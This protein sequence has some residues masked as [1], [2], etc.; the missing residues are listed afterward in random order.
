M[1]P[2]P[3]SLHDECTGRRLHPPRHP[4]RGRS[5]LWYALGKPSPADERAR[6]R[7]LVK[8]IEGSPATGRTHRYQPTL[9]VSQHAP[10]T[11]VNGEDAAF[12]SFRGL[13]PV[14]VPNITDPAYRIANPIDQFIVRRLK[15]R[16]LPQNPPAEAIDL[17]KRVAYDVTGL[18]PAD[19][20]W[21][22]ELDERSYTELVEERLADSAFGERWARLWLDLSRYADSDG[23]EEDDLRPRAFTFR[24]FTIWAMNR[25]LPFNLF[26]QWQIAGDQLE[27]EN[28]M[29]VAATGFLAGAPINVFFPQASERMDELDDVV[30]T[31]GR[32]MLGLSLGCARCHD[33]RYDPIPTTDYYRLVAVLRNT[34]RAHPYLLPDA[35]RRYQQ[36][37]D[38]VTERRTEI[39]QMLLDSLKEQN[40]I[41]LEDFSCEEKA[42]LR[43]PIDP[44]NEEQARLLSRCMRCLWV[45][46]EH[47]DDEST[48]LEEYNERYEE[49]V[50]TI[51]ELAPQLPAPA[52]T[53]LA[54]EGGAPAPFCVL[55]NGD[56]NRK[57]QPV[58]PGF[59]TVLTKGQPQWNETLWREWAPPHVAADALYPR[60]ALAVW[61]TDPENGAGTLLARVIVNRVWQQYFGQGIVQTP[62]DFGHQGA[63]PS[64]PEL[65]EW[66]ANELITHDWK[67]SHI[68]RLILTSA[69]YRQSAT[70]VS[71][72]A[73]VDPENRLLWRQN[74]KRLT[75]E[76]LRDGLLAVADNL[77]RKMYGPGIMPTIPRAAILNTQD[78]VQE[79]WPMLAV[80]DPESLR[81]SIYI[82]TKRSMSVPMMKLFDAPDGSLSCGVRTTTT[83]P[84]QALLLWNSDFVRRQSERVA[85]L[86]ADEVADPE[87]LDALIEAV[88]RRLLLRDASPA[89]RQDCRDFLEAM[90]E[91]P[92]RVPLAALCHTLLLTNEFTYLN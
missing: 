22:V 18:P 57:S 26:V 19:A 88:F 78:T 46:V 73:K 62:S 28:P 49:L 67:L 48:V 30:S 90:R 86:V 79:T 16:G 71:A 85:Q 52:P 51:D 69:T 68:H 63:A 20:S 9:D 75:A 43:Q 31:M 87:D 45:E 91:D 60:T 53:G 40:I 42:L 11:A 80:D 77:N 14:T 4:S 82:I 50:A 59:L 2:P 72:A 6:Y 8:S 81:R 12:W 24:D 23:Y 74:R 83:V 10:S 89:E 44:A 25:D 66:L 84:T 41:E 15:A 29:A 36:R 56:L 37:T 92:T 34:R 70:H 35:G 33:H 13:Q 38:A 65:L 39:L 64:H 1:S 47:L 17:I 27:P 21:P 7:T 54:V 61:L 32:A 3:N 58:Q 55:E 76:M 5:P